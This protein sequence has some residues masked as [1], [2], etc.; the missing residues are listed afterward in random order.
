MKPL[1]EA[2]GCTPPVTRWDPGERDQ[3]QAELDAAY[4]L[5]YGIKRDDA[6]Y[7]LSTF[8]GQRPRGEEGPELFTRVN[9]VLD[10]YDRLWAASEPRHKR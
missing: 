6:A 8:Q 7:I 3:L 2:A 4:F 1:A 9:L 10:T 5:L